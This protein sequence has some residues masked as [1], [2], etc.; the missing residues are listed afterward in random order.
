ML[1]CDFTLPPDLPERAEKPPKKE[2]DAAAAEAVPAKKSKR[3]EPPK[4]PF[5]AMCAE[6]RAQTRTDA[7]KEAF[8]GDP[9]LVRCC[10]FLSLSLFLSSPLHIH[11][12]LICVSVSVCACL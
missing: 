9:T 1:S 2:T 11:P 6:V 8:G 7:F 5:D 4:T 3:P 10:L 12:S